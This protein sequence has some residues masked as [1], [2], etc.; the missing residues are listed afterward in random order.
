MSKFDNPA[1]IMPEKGVFS[2][3]NRTKPLGIAAGVAAIALAIVVS[4]AVLSLAGCLNSTSGENPTEDDTDNYPTHYDF[5]IKNLSQTSDSIRA[6]TITRKYGKS[7][8]AVT[9]YYTGTGGTT[10]ARS[11]TMP[12][13][14]GDYVVTFDVAKATGW[15]AATGLSAGTLTIVSSIYIAGSYTVNDVNTAC[16]WKNGTRTDLQPENAYASSIAVVGTDIYVA[17][18]YKYDNSTRA[19]Y[20]KNGTRTD[21]QPENAYATSIAVV[22]TDVYVAGNYEYGNSTRAC[23]WKNG[24]G[25]YF[26]ED[27]YNRYSQA[28]SITVV[29]TDV[30]V[31]GNNWRGSWMDDSYYRPY[32]LKNDISTDLITGS[33]GSFGETTS[34]TVVGTDVY[35]AGFSEY[36]AHWNETTRGRIETRGACYWKNGNSEIDLDY[37]YYG[38]HY[39]SKSYKQVDNKATSITVV[40]T[41]VYVAGNEGGK[42]CYWN[43]NGREREYLSVP[44]N[45]SA[46]YATGIV[47]VR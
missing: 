28:N 43:G 8:G 33:G 25:I 20:W 34:I 7:G 39:D 11:T 44:D 47:V 12:T 18:N 41:K 24:T 14:T 35:V 13:A 4:M 36:R 46:S 29:G 9:I 3:K 37:N 5:D 21:L 32:Y 6:V 2:V 1:E 17:G 38:Y 23:Y 10:Y 45:S 40:G 42:A 15:K 27:V 26:D 16:Y 31:A 30:Y 22:G 19:C